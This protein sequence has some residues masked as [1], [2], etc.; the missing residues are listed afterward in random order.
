MMCSFIDNQGL[1]IMLTGMAERS[2]QKMEER[3]PEG[4]VSEENRSVFCF[5]C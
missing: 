4:S 3:R 1:L 5:F 2:R